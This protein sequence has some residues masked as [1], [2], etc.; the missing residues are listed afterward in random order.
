[1]PY[2]FTKVAPQNASLAV[3]VCAYNHM[4]EMERC[5]DTPME[6]VR[7]VHFTGGCAKPFRCLD[8]HGPVCQK[9]TEMW[10][11]A[12]REIE[13]KLGYPERPRCP[14]RNYIPI[15]DEATINGHLKA[16]GL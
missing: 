6:Q 4:G 14:N 8:A 7:V 1:M 13:K 3:S 16:L 9:F 2:Y 5:R 11:D 10:W 12:S 15:G